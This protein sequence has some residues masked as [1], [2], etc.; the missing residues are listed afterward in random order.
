MIKVSV[1]VPVYKVENY[2][3]QCLDSIVKQTLEEIEI[4]IVDEGDQDRCREIIDFYEKSD[5]RIIAIHEHN[6][7]YG[8][9]VNKGIE[10]AHG[11]YIGI[12]ESDDWITPNMYEKLYERA[13][14]W[15]PDIVKGSFEYIKGNKALHPDDARGFLMR[16]LPQDI[17]FSISEFPYLLA[18][19]PSVWAGIFRTDFLREHLFI[20]AKGSGYVDAEFYF[21]TY[22]SAKSIVYFPDIIYHWRID[23]ETASCNNWNASVALDRWESNVEKLKQNSKLLEHIGGSVASKIYDTLLK[24]FLTKPEV[25][26]REDVRRVSN[27]L[28]I[29][30]NE[31]IDSAPLLSDMAKADLLACRDNEEDYYK[32]IITRRNM[33]MTSESDQNHNMRVQTVLDKATNPIFL[34]W[35]FFGFA[36][37]LMLLTALKNDMFSFILPNIICQFLCYCCFIAFIIFILGLICVYA[38]KFIGRQ[39]L[40]KL[41]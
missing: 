29:F 25:P 16:N 20:T 2:L 27:C 3:V 31:Q 5:P 36:I 22:C 33:R 15:N 35:L 41:K 10:R 17:P 13:E 34:M 1:I 32:D 28:K 26:T 21:D 4:I 8:A 9:S 24:R 19:H 11:Q 39:L 40:K 18:S 30:T 23:N 37:S 12:V 14:K 38:A 7:G 6:G